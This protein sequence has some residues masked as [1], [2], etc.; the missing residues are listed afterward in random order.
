M[1]IFLF[2]RIHRNIK[3][4]YLDRIIRFFA[5]LKKQVMNE[6]AYYLQLG[7]ASISAVMAVVFAYYN[8]KK[9]LFNQILSLQFMLVAYGLFVSFF[10]FNNLFVVY[11]HVSRT[12][13]LCAMLLPPLSFLALEKGI[14][15]KRIRAID[16]LHLAPAALYIVNFWNYFP[17]SAA[18]KVAVLQNY[19]IGEFEEGYLP[20][21]FLPAVSIAQTTFYLIA[22]ASLIK[23]IKPALASNPVRHLVYYIFGYLI[24][25][26]LPPI[27]GALHY[28]DAQAITSWMPVLYASANI[29]F[30]FKVLGTPEWLFGLHATNSSKPS[31]R[32]ALK[33]DEPLEIEQQ[34]MDLLSPKTLELS[35]DEM[36]LFSRFTKIIEAD[37][38]YLSPNFTQKNLAVQLH[39]S[40][41]KLRLLLD[42]TYAMKFSDFL[43]YRKIYY[44][45]NEYRKNPQ[46]KKFSIAAIARI[47]GYSSVNS[48]YLN[49]KRITG[50]T[51][52]DYFNEL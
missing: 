35:A 26:Y 38:L 15:K 3:I 6:L 28:Y 27:M 22:Y 21:Y 13:L 10:A 32:V 46:W 43:N 4:R 7:T 1:G 39:T 25:N 29:F 47:L 49:F 45:I 24:L 40:E 52:K 34:I 12:G 11:P 19:S 42:K 2:F 17:L 20:P 31:P 36:D 44:C 23:K 8:W 16:L 18:E 30:F 37:K 33:V 41:Y 14:G 48:F 51:P 5:L 9:G 50:L